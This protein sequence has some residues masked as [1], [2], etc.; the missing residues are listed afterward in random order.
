MTLATSGC[1]GPRADSRILMERRQSG[2]ARA[3]LP[4][5]QYATAWSWSWTANATGS[6][7]RLLRF[8]RVVGDDTLFNPRSSSRMQGGGNAHRHAPISTYSKGMKQR[9][10]ISAALLGLHCG[11]SEVLH[12]ADSE[13]HKKQQAP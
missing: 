8:T 7:F 12:P 5:P 10:L 9:V 11:S 13:T 2:L 6:S 1:L 3:S 4:W